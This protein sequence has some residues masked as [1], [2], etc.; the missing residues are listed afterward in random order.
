[1]D[2]GAIERSIW[3]AAPRE[4]VW[5]AITAPEQIAQW[6]I[7]NLP[8]A[9]ITQDDSDKLTIHIGPKGIDFVIIEA[10]DPPRQVTSR[11]LPDRSIATTYTL[12]E[13]GGGTL[14]TVA[15][16]G[17]ESLAEDARGDRLNLSG[18]GWEKA[19]KNL[20]A[21]VD[22]VELPFP[23]AFVGPLFGYWKEPRKKLAIERSIWIHAPRERVWRA[24]T[25]PEQI[26]KW[27]APGT[28]FKSSG[29]GVGAKL[30]IE[31]PETGE[32]MHVQILEH[33][34]PPHRL[35][36]RSASGTPHI[37]AWTLAEENGGT[38]LTLTYSGYEQ[39]PD[40]TRWRN[41]EENAFGFGMM[42]GN[43][44]AFIE[45]VSLPQPEGF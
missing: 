35:T 3:I 21:Y 6:L 9:Q 34:E 43:V 38:R 18:E 25:D 19:L 11:G 4:R 15:M 33:V 37:T 40:D 39:E 31:N 10:I 23:Q 26:E 12:E 41:M 44:K 7:P 13:E 36:T 2:T 29:S 14:V 22:G 45:G 24:I 20:K 30:Y 16:T 17:F 5:Q 8:G 28:T 32:E 1:M 27:F 42:L